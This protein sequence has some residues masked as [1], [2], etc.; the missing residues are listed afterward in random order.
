MVTKG[1]VCKYYEKFPCVEG[2]DIAYTFP[3]EAFAKYLVQLRDQPWLAGRE[4]PRPDRV[5]RPTSPVPGRPRPGTFAHGR[6]SMPAE[7]SGIAAAPR[8]ARHRQ[9]LRRRRRPFRRRVHHRPG[10]G[11]G[12]ARLEWRR[13]IDADEDPD[14]PL[15]ARRRHHPDRRARNR[16]RRSPPGGCRGRQ[17]PAAGNLGHARHDR[18]RK[19]HDRRPADARRLGRRQDDAPARRRRADP[20]RLPGHRRRRPR[21]VAVDCRTADRRDR[22]GPRRAGAHPRH[23]RADGVAHRTGGG[24]HLPDHPPA[25]GTAGVDHLHLPLSEGGLRHLRP[26]RGAPRRPQRRR[27]SDAIGEARGRGRGD[28]RRRRRRPLRHRCS[29]AAG[30]D[31]IVRRGSDRQEPPPWRP[32]RR[33]RRTRSSASSASSDP[34]SRPSDGRSTAPSVPM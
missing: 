9:I 7:I 6:S 27:F 14:R 33:P 19:R 5:G 23:G 29:V 25:Q 11:G 17:I 15:H 32:P 2:K 16:H 18:R 21:R 24:T 28:A 10:R 22:Q 31:G 12:A 13:Q 34:A 30:G 8:N 4:E 26:H 20:A 3:Q 1:N